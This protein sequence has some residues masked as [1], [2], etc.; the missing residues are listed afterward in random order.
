MTDLSDMSIQRLAERIEALE[1]ENAAANGLLAKALERIER[2]ERLA[3]EHDMLH[4]ACAGR[5]ARDQH[6]ASQSRI[7]YDAARKIADRIVGR[8]CYELERPKQEGGTK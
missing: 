3:L 4:E 7:A 1:A 8:I 5:F 2:L 6:H